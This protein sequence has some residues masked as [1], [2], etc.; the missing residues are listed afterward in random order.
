MPGA[1]QNLG[2]QKPLFSTQVHLNPVRGEHD[3]RT[4]NSTE[5]DWERH[6]VIE[7]TGSS[8][9]VY[10]EL[11]DVKHGNIGSHAGSSDLA[12]LMVYRFRFGECFLPQPPCPYPTL[13]LPIYVM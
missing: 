4:R 5:S 7:R 1:T 11:M 8:I 10:C 3:L 12:T 13:Q 6:N 2:S 9:D